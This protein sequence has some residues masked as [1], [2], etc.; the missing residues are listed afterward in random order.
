MP[1]KPAKKSRTVTHERPQSQSEKARDKA[2]AAKSKQLDRAGTALLD[3]KPSKAKKILE[4]KPK[5]LSAAQAVQIVSEAKSVEMRLT[6][7]E[8]R[9]DGLKEEYKEA[10]AEREKLIAQLRSEVRDAH[11]GRLPFTDVPA[12]PAKS[13]AAAKSETKPGENG[14]HAASDDIEH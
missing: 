14:T 1:K 11:Q 13:K 12:A 2:E 8:H 3:G 5:P 6:A 4:A 10:K 9:I 7:V